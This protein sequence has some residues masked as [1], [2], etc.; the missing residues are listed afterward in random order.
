MEALQWGPRLTQSPPKAPLRTEQHNWPGHRWRGMS[1]HIMTNDIILDV[2][3]SFLVA[4][5]TQAFTAICNSVSLSHILC[6]TPSANHNPSA[7]CPTLSANQNKINTVHL[8]YCL[9]LIIWWL[10]LILYT[11]YIYNT[12]SNIQ[13]IREQLMQSSTN[14]WEEW[15]N[16]IKPSEIKLPSKTIRN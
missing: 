6:P 14:W 3:W 8:L 16:L 11:L 10:T 15:W 9:S 2:C 13:T 4:N 12:P 5:A 7:L 1:N